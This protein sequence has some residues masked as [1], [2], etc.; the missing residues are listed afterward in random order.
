MATVPGT[1]AA[2]GAAAAEIDAVGDS[3]GRLGGRWPCLIAIFAMLFAGC[4]SDASQPAD[5]AAVAAAPAAQVAERGSTPAP[6]PLTREQLLD[7]FVGD[8]TVTRAAPSDADENIS[9]FIRREGDTLAIFEG[10]IRELDVRIESVDPATGTVS[11]VDTLPDK[12]QALTLTPVGVRAS[13]DSVKLDVV[14]AWGDGVRWTLT[15]GAFSADPE[16]HSNDL[17]GIVRARGRRGVHRVEN[18]ACGEN[19]RPRHRILCEDM[20]LRHRH[21]D[22]MEKFMSVG[23]EYPD[24]HR[25]YQ[26]AIRNLDTCADKACIASTIDMWSRYLDD[27]YPMQQMVD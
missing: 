26:A 6:V 15:G 8:W 25:T 3:G 27:N 20:D 21:F 10:G 17:I 14:M 7:R 23:G 19:A 22:L 1:V 18:I 13:V 4:S 2:M 24:S 11:L 5:D 12:A 9:V 16:A